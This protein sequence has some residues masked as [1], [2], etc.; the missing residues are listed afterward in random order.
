MCCNKCSADTNDPED[1]KD[2]SHTGFEC[3][4]T[5]TCEEECCVIVHYEVGYVSA[6]ESSLGID[7]AYKAMTTLCGPVPGAIR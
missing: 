4:L 6:V 5:A 1:V 7:L 3:K 2:K